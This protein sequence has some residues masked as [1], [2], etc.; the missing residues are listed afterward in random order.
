MIELDQLV[1]A[2]DAVLATAA[3]K[4]SQQEIAETLR[5][6]SSQIS[7]LQAV[8]SD[9]TVA[10]GRTGAHQAA[11]HRSPA[12][13]LKRECHY[14]GAQAQAVAHSGTVL[15]ESL[16]ATSAALRAGTITWPHATTLVRGVEALGAEDVATIEETW[17]EKIAEQCGPERLQRAVRARVHEKTPEPKPRAGQGT[18]SPQGI[19][20]RQLGGRGYE[21]TGFLS[22]DDGATIEQAK[23]KLHSLDLPAGGSDAVATI[24]GQWLRQTSRHPPMKREQSTSQQNLVGLF[25]LT[26][27]DNAEPLVSSPTIKRFC[28]VD[29]IPLAEPPRIV[30][31]REPAASSLHRDGACEQPGCSAKPKWCDYHGI[32][33]QLGSRQLTAA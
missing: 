18:P 16:P 8:I 28:D 13:F 14:S 24:V 9:H 22:L 31:T 10:M 5:V 33:G 6:V 15:E 3:A 27:T 29:P 30:R 1:G 23:A 26:R 21:V 17:V 11:G 32:I 7:R 19:A 20:L 25:G 4:K 12:E 2:V